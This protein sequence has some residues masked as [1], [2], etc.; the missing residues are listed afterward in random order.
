MDLIAFFQQKLSQISAILTGNT[1]DKC[2]LHSLI[3]HNLVD[4]VH[5]FFKLYFEPRNNCVNHAFCRLQ[6][7]TTG[8][9][10][11]QNARYPYQAWQSDGE[12]EVILVH[13]V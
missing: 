3:P 9:L 7:G 11:R 6:S 8:H 13:I 12:A 10:K 5:L 2:S 4:F 1:S